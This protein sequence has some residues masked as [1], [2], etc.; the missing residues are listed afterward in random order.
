MLDGGGGP[1]RLDGGPGDDLARSYALLGGPGN[2]VLRGG[3]G[4]DSLDG[5]AGKDVCKGGPGSDR[6]HGGLPGGGR[7][8][9]VCGR[10][11]ETS[12]GCR[13]GRKR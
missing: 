5:G 8:P 7:D 10:D 2:D 13:G 11:V 9:D 4:D 1:D 6:C 12:A 3:E